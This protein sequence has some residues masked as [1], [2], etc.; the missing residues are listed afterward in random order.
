MFGMKL[1][2]VPES[3]ANII[4]IVKT[5][6]CISGMGLYEA[7]VNTFEK[8]KKG[9]PVIFVQ[10]AKDPDEINGYPALSLNQAKKEL[11]G[12]GA[13]VEIFC[14]DPY[15]FHLRALRAALKALNALKSP[16]PMLVQMEI[17]AVM[18]AGCGSNEA[19]NDAANNDD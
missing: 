14:Q 1:L 15:Q 13:T 5:I 9:Q 4:G 8:A 7:K 10:G 11:E 18:L 17:E 19:V 6:R 12:Y 3:N 16:D 2:S